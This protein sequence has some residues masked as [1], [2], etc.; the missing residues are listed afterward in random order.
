MPPA[1]LDSQLGTLEPLAPDEPG[2]AVSIE[3]APD[4]IVAAICARLEA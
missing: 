4:D 1:L 3:A 2:F